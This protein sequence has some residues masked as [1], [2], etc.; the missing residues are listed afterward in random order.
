MTSESNIQEFRT[1]HLEPRSTNNKFTNMLLQ[2]PRRLYNLLKMTDVDSETGRNIKYWLDSTNEYST[3]YSTGPQILFYLCGKGKGTHMPAIDENDQ[4]CG[5]DIISNIG[6][7]ESIGIS[8][9]KMM[10][11]FQPDLSVCNYYGETSMNVSISLKILLQRGPTTR[12]SSIL[13]TTVYSL[14]I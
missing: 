2:E 10:L 13:L 9:F 1:G 7:T 8:I 5:T 3:W 6:I 12:T 11:K 4:F 14:I